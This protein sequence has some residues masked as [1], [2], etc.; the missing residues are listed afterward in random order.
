MKNDCPR[1]CLKLNGLNLASSQLVCTAVAFQRANNFCHLTLDLAFCFIPESC[2]KAALLLLPQSVRRQWYQLRYFGITWS[3]AFRSA[4]VCC[5]VT[6]L[7][8]LCFWKSHI[9]AFIVVLHGGNLKKKKRNLVVAEPDAVISA[10]NSQQGNK[11]QNRFKAS[12][13]LECI[14]KTALLGLSTFHI[15]LIFC[16]SVCFYG[17][18]AS[19]C[20]AHLHSGLCQHHVLTSPQPP[21]LIPNS[22][23]VL[24]LVMFRAAH[25]N[26]RMV[27]DCY[28]MLK[29]FPLAGFS[30]GSLPG[31]FS[32]V[33][34]VKL[35]LITVPVTEN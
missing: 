21:R 27:N 11:D 31:L 25:S 1:L 5:L 34:M 20:R 2:H 7:Q 10:I 28:Y 9:V 30:F 24:N 19:F 15:F 14:L 4:F 33:A 12:V 16:A 6:S 23:D 22:P 26:I 8:G 35:V 32:M 18:G 3:W 29:E 13:F 17:D